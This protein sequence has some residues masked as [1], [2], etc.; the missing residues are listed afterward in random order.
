MPI[1]SSVLFPAD[2]NPTLD[3]GSPT[4]TGSITSAMKLAEGMGAKLEIDAPTRIYKRGWGTGFHD[5]EEI[6]AS[7]TLVCQK[8]DNRNT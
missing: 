3:E 8:V 1:E 5:A 4:S 7:W 2:P 6:F